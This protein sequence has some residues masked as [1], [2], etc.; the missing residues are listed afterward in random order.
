MR[1]GDAL[2]PLY[3]EHGPF[4]CS[5]QILSFVTFKFIYKIIWSIK[6]DW[7]VQA[8]QVSNVLHNMKCYNNYIELSSMIVDLPFV[9]P[10]SV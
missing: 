3:P 6:H 9:Y 2:S 10:I 5:S 4:V 8:L 7:Q 1:H